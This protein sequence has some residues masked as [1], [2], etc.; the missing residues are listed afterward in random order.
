MT[1][2]P[3]AAQ[4][5]ARA[6]Q[7]AGVQLREVADLAG[8]VAVQQLFEGIWKPDPHHPPVTT[9]LLR[10]LTKAG[11]YVVAA[12][13]QGRMVGACVAF[14]GPP[15]EAAMH[16]HIAGVV[17]DQAGRSVGYAVKLHQR[18]WALD[19]GV[20]TISWTF[21]P[22][23]SRNAYFNLVKLGAAAG[24][25][26]PNFYGGMH[27]GINGGDETDRMLVRWELAA[28]RSGVTGA[29]QAV[30]ALGRTAEGGPAIGS[31]DGDTLLVAVP[32]DV[33]AL[34]AN[35]SA[36]ARRWRGALREVLAPLMA[37]GARVTGFDKTGSYVL[38]REGR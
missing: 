17:P 6:A 28:P 25:Y 37:D 14:F 27:D 16:S 34:R 5:A 24:E 35:D 31:L 4:E 1:A 36:L 21:D 29:E 38:R 30:V 7:A 20:R 8:F 11:N 18:A 13:R 12:E 26:L 22:L 32:V 10:A 9:E 23:V 19:R 15:G 33:E 3:T 2:L